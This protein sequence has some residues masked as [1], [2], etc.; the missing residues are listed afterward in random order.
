M[1]LGILWL[2]WMTC[3]TACPP[4]STRE[5]RN[6][7]A[8]P[9]QPSTCPQLPTGVFAYDRRTGLDLR[10]SI[11]GVQ[12]RV[13]VHAISFA[14]LPGE[15]ATGFL[16]VPPRRGKSEHLAGIVVQHGMPG[17]ARDAFRDAVNLAR[18]GA[19]AIA[20]DAPWNNRT[21]EVIHFTPQDSVE[22]VQLIVN[23]RRAFDILSARSDVDSTRLAYTGRSYGG[24][25][26]GLL[27]GVEHRPVTYVLIVGDG[28]LVAHFTDD[29]TGAFRSVI[30][31]QTS[32][33]QVD[34]WLAAMRPI[35]PI[36][37]IPCARTRILFLSG[38]IDRL[39]TE[40]DARAYQDAAPEPKTIRWFELGHGLGIPAK[41][42]EL[43]WLHETIGTDPAGTPESWE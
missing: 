42:A 8:S 31:S 22:Q 27:A 25:M 5:Q 13:E 14:S 4:K 23:L 36:R 29:T 10:D 17:S 9:I 34:R 35:E 2:C 21:G 41:I 28:G 6:A 11:V 26:G 24:A 19:V 32:S 30:Q 3:L 40:A 12:S 18:H 15:R 43:N 37:Y 33:Q 1:R 16:F 20:L 7:Q 38:R 39:V